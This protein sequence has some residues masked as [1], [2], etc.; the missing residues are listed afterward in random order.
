MTRVLKKVEMHCRVP[1]RSI[2]TLEVRRRE[3]LDS[4]LLY[5]QVLPLGEQPM[6]RSVSG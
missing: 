6:P 1:E 5:N 3:G 4:T 2:D